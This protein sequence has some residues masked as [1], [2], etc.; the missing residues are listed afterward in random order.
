MA[1]NYEDMTDVQFDALLEQQVAAMDAAA[2][3]AVPGV[4]EVLSEHLNNEVLEQW[5]F[6]MDAKEN[7]DIVVLYG[8]RVYAA[9]ASEGV[10]RLRINP[11]EGW[12]GIPEGP[13]NKMPLPTDEA[14]LI[15]W[16]GNNL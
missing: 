12:D 16:L 5:D 13:L 10:S 15:A 3:L 14:T 11:H 4:Y 9:N 1:G 6:M 2:L 8:G 7:G